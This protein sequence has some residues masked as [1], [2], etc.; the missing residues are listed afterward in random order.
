MA[1][2]GQHQEALHAMWLQMGG[3]IAQ[4]CITGNNPVER[5]TGTELIQRWLQ[6]TGIDGA[7]ALAAKQKIAASLLEQVTNI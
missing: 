5:A 6:S 3:G 2:Q 1:Q 7:E 4:A